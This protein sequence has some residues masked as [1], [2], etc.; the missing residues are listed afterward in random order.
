MLMRPIKVINNFSMFNQLENNDDLGFGAHASYIMSDTTNNFG[1][2]IYVGNKI[3]DLYLNIGFNFNSFSYE[4][5]INDFSGRSYGLD[6]RAKQSFNDFEYSIPITV[7]VS[8]TFNCP[9]KL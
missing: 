3:E 8:L 9:S 4:D 2:R 6:I 7:L 5:N 1:G